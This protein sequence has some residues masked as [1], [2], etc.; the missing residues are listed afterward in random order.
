MDA[1]RSHPAVQAAKPGHLALPP[2][3]TPLQHI[4]ADLAGLVLHL[5]HSHQLGSQAAQ[6]AQVQARL[7]IQPAAHV[8]AE[9]VLAQPAKCAGSGAKAEEGRLLGRTSGSD[10]AASHEFCLGGAMQG[11]RPQPNSSWSV[12]KVLVCLPAP[13]CCLLASLTCT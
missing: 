6:R 10:V 7:L 9:S 2:V 11:P 12:R 13:Q 3:L 1:V 4:A 8:V 5:L